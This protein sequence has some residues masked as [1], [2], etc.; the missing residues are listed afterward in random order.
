MCST[1]IAFPCATGYLEQHAAKTGSTAAAA[2]LTGWEGALR[3]FV[4]VMPTDYKRVLRQQ[5]A[6]AAADIAVAAGA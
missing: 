4:K 6:A 1:T 5:E 3:Q 2:L